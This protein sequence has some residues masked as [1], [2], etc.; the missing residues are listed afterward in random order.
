LRMFMAA[1]SK[2]LFQLT[3]S[4]SPAFEE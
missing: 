1:L 2:L 3:E 4:V